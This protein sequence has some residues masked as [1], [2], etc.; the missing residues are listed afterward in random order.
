MEKSELSEIPQPPETVLVGNLLDLDRA[1]PV[2]GLARL[3]RE[4]GPIFKLRMRKTF[5]VVVSGHRL[6]EELCDEKRFDKSIAGALSKVRKFAGDG[7]FTSR[8]DEPNWS[9]AHNIL[10]PAFSARAMR[11]YHEMMLDIAGQLAAKWSRLNA[12]DEI[13]V[14]RDMTSL[15]LDTIGLC[16][17]DYRFNSFYRESSHP[18][19]GAMVD[20][21][22]CAM[23][24]VRRLPLE[25]WIRIAR[26]R[27]FAGDIEYMNGMVDRIVRERREA[28]A[29]TGER[30][31]LL[32]FMLSGVDKKSGERLDDL[33]IRYQIITF[34]I[35]GHETTSGLLSFAINALVNNPD[36]LR[37]AYDEVDRTLG[38]DR[39][40]LPTYA[41][42]NQL[43]YLNQILK[44]TLRLWPTAPAFS[45]YPLADTVIGGRYE[46]KR[47]W[48]MM[49][50][51]PALHRD[52]EVWGERAEVFDPENFAPAAEAARPASAY[53]PFGNG[54]RAC[55]G[56]QFA[57]QEAALV[58]AMVLQRFKLIDHKR[59]K[60]KIKETL[61]LKPDG[62]TIRVRPRSAHER[63][64]AGRDA[65]PAGAGM[66]TVNGDEAAVSPTAASAA[67]RH[68]RPLLALYGSNLGTAEEIARRIAQD[69]DARGFSASAAPL[70]D[71]AGRLPNDGAVIIVTASYN[72]T[73]PDN[74]AKFCEWLGDGMAPNALS[75]VRYAVFG[76][77]N[78]DWTATFQAVPRLIDGAMESHG[79]ERIAA[80]GEGD[81]RDDFDG[82]FQNWSRS[83]WPALAEKLDV[84]LEPT[85]AARASLYEVET[86]A[87]DGRGALAE[88]L[89][90]RMMRI[91]EI[92]ELHNKEG[93]QPSARSARHLEVELPEG[94]SYRAGDHLGVAPRNPAATVR[95][96]MR[97]F[98]FAG[99]ETIRLRAASQ[100]RAP[101]PI[102][103]PIA[104]AAL[105]RDFPELQAVATRSQIE[106]LA[107]HTPC[108]PER[109]R[110][111]ALAGDDEAAAARYRDD[112][113]AR[114][115]SLIDLLEETPSCALPF[116][117]YLEMLPLLAPRYYSI[118]SSPL[119]DPRRCSI[120]V[121][122]V[123]GPARSGHGEYLGACSSYLSGLA[124]G[125]SIAAFVKDN[126]SNFRLPD[127]PAKPVVMVGP[128]TGIAPFRGF[129]QERAALK[130]GGTE[131]GPAMLFFG[132]RRPDQ[133][134]IYADELRKFE[135]DG[136]VRV[137]VAYSRLGDRKVYVQ[138]KIAESRDDLWRLI[139]DGAIIYICGDASQMAPGVRAAFAALY[140]A[141]TGADRVAADAWIDR[142]VGEGRYRVDVWSAG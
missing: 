13:D 113:M 1:A 23:E 69:A 120:T 117:V 95:R 5:L 136:V 10:L 16:G 122:V 41:Q 9:K 106:I 86:V 15:T 131:I 46:I 142:I 105:L 141:K 44:E 61:T 8:T 54:Q 28:G 42:V 25:D 19:V 84:A 81:A 11:S 35:A 47:E 17:F 3:A 74:A 73:P 93:A 18:F 21:L 92:R 79:A 125:D 129:L 51:L 4:Y 100:R 70:D 50:L 56:R 107:E 55:I 52:P 67:A 64:G 76:C 85:A 60:L 45:L 109:A 121:G 63:L 134:F 128:G 115:K 6:V 24:Q 65:H 114:R 130:R 138:D 39:D 29:E 2:Q 127:D 123:A 137:I 22:S 110:L 78:R 102:D 68:G 98:G 132:C 59:Y 135:N 75:G 88:A 30:R 96:V 14:A 83:L 53:K 91:V 103:R 87:S 7:L 71:Y 62:F 27:R 36:V 32:T 99:D 34:L 40:A 82:Q 140:S 126:H 43:G 118:S 119:A 111:A 12:D 66:Q 108:P 139:E 26:D 90:A 124:P 94:V 49:V 116:A 20:A 58:L 33:N 101:L 38:P 31:D 112:V 57:I 72:G 89:A 37:R 80:R 48:Q 97:R 133:D 104:I 77:G